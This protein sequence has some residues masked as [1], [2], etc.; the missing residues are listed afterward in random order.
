MAK[1]NL[2]RKRRR[3][4]VEILVGL[5]VLLLAIWLFMP[6]ILDTLRGHP[7]DE[8]DASAS[9][10]LR[11]LSELEVAEVGTGGDAPPYVRT[12]FG[13]GWA[14][15]DGDGCNTRNEILARDM[16]EVRFR[17]RTDDCVVES[18]V[19]SDPYTDTTI[20]FE[21]GQET[22]QAVQ[23]DHVVALADGWRA[24][25]WSWDA[26][27]RLEFANDPLNLLA[28]DGLANQAKGASTADRWLPD[29]G[30]YHCQY[31]A[32]QVAVKYKWD[33]TVTREERQ[34]LN[35]ILSGCADSA[36]K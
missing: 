10:S 22:S 19:L 32:R 29:N 30:D 7:L 12:E 27:E 36:D 17:P 8:V 14:D 33:L 5:G 18:G 21:R 4:L 6:S 2:L 11:K 23:I 15:L 20:Y 26:R 35:G 34:A 25:A 31:A 9:E 3:S 28:V 16:S 13:D 1:K 24:G